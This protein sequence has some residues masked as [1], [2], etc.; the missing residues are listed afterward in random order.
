MILNSYYLARNLN[1]GDFFVV[2]QKLI[3]FIDID[4]V[5]FALTV[6]RLLAIFHGQ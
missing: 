3:H 1:P 5:P 6:S 2:G 4:R